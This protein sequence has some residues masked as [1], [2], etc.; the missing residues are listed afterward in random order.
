[1]ADLQILKKENILLNQPGADREEIIRRCGRM[2]ADSGYVR[3]RYIEGMVKRDNSF[4]TCI[5]NHIALPHGEAEYKADIIST[6]IVVLTYPG[7]I[8]WQGMRVYLVIGIAAK[9]DQ[10]LDIM[11]NIVDNLETGDDVIRLVNEGDVERVYTMLCGD[12][13]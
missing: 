3:E 2:L 5:G 10:H 7:G 13:A 1:M 9:G 6:G 11:G 4:S 12:Q 8:D